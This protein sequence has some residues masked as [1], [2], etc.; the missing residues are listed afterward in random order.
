MR[1]KILLRAFYI[2]LKSLTS[3]FSPYVV[4]DLSTESSQEYFLCS[5]LICSSFEKLFDFDF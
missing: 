1:S 5:V 2:S 3:K 4:I